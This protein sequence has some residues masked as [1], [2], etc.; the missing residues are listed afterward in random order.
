RVSVNYALTDAKFRSTF[1]TGS[2]GNSSATPPADSAGEI[3]GGLI[4][5]EPGDRMPGVPLHNLN[6]SVS[7]DITPNWTV[8]LG[9]VLHSWSFLR[10]N[11]NNDHEAGVPRPVIIRTFNPDGS[12]AG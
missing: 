8:G 6:A 3:Y 4:T 9:A 2:I 7:Y 11:E 12:F 5:V 10:G 1:V